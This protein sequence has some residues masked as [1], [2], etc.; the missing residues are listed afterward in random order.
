MEEI[1]IAP[2]H[3]DGNLGYH[4][5]FKYIIKLVEDNDLEGTYVECGVKSGRS[6]KLIAQIIMR[7]LSTRPKLWGYD[8][9]EGFPEPSSQDLPGKAKKGMHNFNMDKCYQTIAATGYKD[10]KLVKG[11][12]QDTLPDHYTGGP[13][14]VLNLDSDLYQSYKDCFCLVEKVVPGGIIMFDEYKSPTQLKHYPGPAL[15]VDEYFGTEIKNIKK[16]IMQ[17]APGWQ[18]HYLIKNF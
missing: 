2:G 10:F 6:M 5:Y 18:K 3:T 17:D 11:F 13:I 14:A 15:A 1:R 8:S 9:F 12:F 4:E 7:N 16:V